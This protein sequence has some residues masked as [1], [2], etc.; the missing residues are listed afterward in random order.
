[1]IDSWR[2]QTMT[3]VLHIS[4]S[5]EKALQQKIQNVVDELKHIEHL[6]IH[7]Q[8]KPLRQFE[9]YK[10][11]LS[12]IPRD[13]DLYIIFTDDDDIW[14]PQRVEA[15]FVS[16]QDTLK[17]SPD[18][19]W[20]SLKFPCYAYNEQ[21]ETVDNVIKQMADCY[22]PNSKVKSIRVM[23]G[24]AEY[25]MHLVHIHT[26]RQFVSSC[27]DTLLQN[28]FCDQYFLKFM[29]L[30]VGYQN[31]TIDNDFCPYY[32][33]NNQQSASITN[34]LTSETNIQQ[35]VYKHAQDNV[36]L[37]D[38]RTMK[39]VQQSYG[40]DA[41]DVFIKEA[42]NN[43]SMYAVKRSTMKKSDFYKF[44]RSAGSTVPDS[45]W[46]F[47]LATSKHPYFEEL[48]LSPVYGGNRIV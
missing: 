29:Y 36:H 31:V 22:K 17:R 42:V 1:M 12:T 23:E 27:S 9:H 20:L 35:D 30:C 21:G 39:C 19:K 37:I 15:Y 10:F 28:V 40:D 38:K 33:R 5:F 32:Y 6:V 48:L 2:M 26:L 18:A 41:V 11:L 13:D 25:F 14:A 8:D 4:I 3:C 7:L 16:L 47:I 24:F 44:A 45:H 43:I 46:P 34:Q